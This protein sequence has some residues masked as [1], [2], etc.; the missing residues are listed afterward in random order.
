MSPTSGFWER[1]L[2]VA[3]DINATSYYELLGL[4]PDASADDVRDAYYKL[5]R[6][7]HPDRHARQ[8]DERRRALTI[9][10]A[11]LGEG[12]RVLSNPSARAEYD[13]GLAA[14]KQRHTEAEKQRS[15]RDDR[16][17]R[18]PQ[19]KTLFEEGQRLL[20]AGDK[21]GARSRWDL[22]RQFEPGS[23]A[24]AAAIAELKEA[25]RQRL[26]PEQP[27]PV[28]ETAEPKAADTPPPALKRQQPRADTRHPLARPVKIRCKSW[29]KVQTLY[30][31]DISRGGMFLRTTK[32]IEQGTPLRIVLTLPDERVLE[33]EAEVAR[34]VT[35]ADADKRGPGMGIRFLDVDAKRQQLEDILAS[36][37]TSKA[38]LD[39]G[40]EP[41][42]LRPPT[43]PPAIVKPSTAPT[44]ADEVKVLAEL[45]KTLASSMAQSPVARL[46]VPD[47][48]DLTAVR[49]GW[50]VMAKRYHPDHFRRYAATD[51]HE[52]A[53]ELFYVLRMTYEKLRQHLGNAASQTSAPS[54]TGGPSAAQLERA[55]A[56]D[57]NNGSLRARYHVAAGHEAL[58]GGDRAGARQHFESA[59]VFDK[60]CHEAIEALRGGEQR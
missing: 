34:V 6:L 12:Y 13:Q 35:A 59:L 33:L 56:Q 49:K 14:G 9:V 53:S 32:A 43:Q 3:A 42:T 7:L 57:P 52:T 48:S 28:A 16:D 21:K 23:K 25:E 45:R 27:A 19:A 41:S 1:I 17:P 15:L 4:S 46:G 5:V 44:A 60:Q 18:N 31:R 2:G 54:R 50:L 20:A 30:T 40:E 11:R 8:S 26:A 58:A 29:D 36:L 38:K 47:G 39:L 37:P 51:I 22:A 24:I 10:Y 55:V